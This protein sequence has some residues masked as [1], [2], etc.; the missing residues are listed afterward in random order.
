MEDSVQILLVFFDSGELPTAK[1][2]RLGSVWELREEGKEEETQV[3][4][5]VGREWV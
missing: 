4:R 2:G 1:L 5:K 3:R